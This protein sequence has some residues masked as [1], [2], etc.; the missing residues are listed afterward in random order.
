MAT[1]VIMPKL[2]ESITEGTIVEWKKNVG[3]KISR[4]E[5]ILEISTDKVDSEIPSPAAG[6]LLEVLYK[7]NET[8]AVGEVIARIGDPGE[9]ITTTK[10]EVKIVSKEEVETPTPQA[11]T[12]EDRPQENKQLQARKFYSP[13]VRSI[14]KKEGINLSELDAVNGTGHNG[15][16][17][18]HDILSYIKSKGE[19]VDDIT[20]DK[21]A[22]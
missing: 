12:K 9:K 19:I 13:L 16:I 11:E 18:K 2:G 10:K 20:V 17:N 7:K 4:D 6:T 8:V 14:A 22:K 3:D 1:D 5:T 15:R 21:S